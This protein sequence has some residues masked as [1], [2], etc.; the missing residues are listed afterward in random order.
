[1]GKLWLL[2]CLPPTHTKP[3]YGGYSK[4]CGSHDEETF[5]QHLLCA[6]PCTEH[7]KKIQKKRKM[8]PLRLR[9]H[10]IN[11]ESVVFQIE[12]PGVQCSTFTEGLFQARGGA[13]G[14]RLLTPFCPSPASGLP[15]S[16]CAVVWPSLWG[17]GST[18]L[19]QMNVTCGGRCS[20]APGSQGTVQRAWAHLRG[21]GCRADGRGLALAVP[22]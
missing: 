7:F 21:E 19:A 4:R 5:M 12:A 2:H 17:P 13:A 8:Q 10:I 16:L 1:M 9:V 11:D 3:R 14:E 15:P 20:P 22:S 6:G 18:A